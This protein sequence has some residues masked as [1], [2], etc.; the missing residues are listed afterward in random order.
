MWV[1]IAI[2]EHS[3]A[4][5]LSFSSILIFVACL[6]RKSYKLIWNDSPPLLCVLV[7]IVPTATLTC[8]V[9][10]EWIL[11][12]AGVIPKSPKY[13]IMIHFPSAMAMT[14]GWFYDGAIASA[15]L[16]RILIL[17]PYFQA[18]KT[19]YKPVVVASVLIPLL[20]ILSILTLN[21][22]FVS[23]DVVPASPDCFAPNCMSSHVAFI[24]QI[25]SYVDLSFSIGVLITGSTSLA[26]LY[27]YRKNFQTY[28]NANIN[29]FSRY[30]FY[31]RLTFKFSPFLADVV[32]SNTVGRPLAA[33]IG[34]Y[35]ALGGSFEA[36]LCILAFYSLQ[37]K[38][39]QRVISMS[40]SGHMISNISQ[41]AS[42]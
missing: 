23:V 5:L 38:Q 40:K 35:G 16:H 6:K 41:K 31:L 21:V 27:R 26:L 20:C 15:F 37:K 7:S 12:C 8:L 14:A 13:T 18:T 29:L 3:I 33:Y 30:I 36:F 28:K 9:M 19:F 17:L 10:L 42:R 4:S 22:V 39:T 2:I 34:P 1:G 24:R 32:V 25:Y 11:I